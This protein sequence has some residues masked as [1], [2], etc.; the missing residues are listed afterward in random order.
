MRLFIEPA[1]KA[2]Q[3]LDTYAVALGHGF[4]AYQTRSPQGTRHQAWKDS[5]DALVYA[6]GSDVEPPIA[7]CE[8]QGFVYL[9][10]LHLSEVL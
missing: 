6:D 7:T 5:S 4:D 10:K 9:A 1:L 2:L 3:W 8:E